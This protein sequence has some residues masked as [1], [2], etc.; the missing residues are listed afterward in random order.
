MLNNREAYL[1]LSAMLRARESRMLTEER[2]RRMLDAPT[3]EDA[4][5]LLTDCGYEDMSGMNA[6]EIEAALAAHRDGI[7]EEISRLAPDSV[8]PD[9]FK[10]KYDYHNAKVILKSEAMNLDPDALLVSSGRI[11][12][13]KLKLLYNEEKYSEMP[14]ALGTA[15]EQAKALLARSANPQQTDFLLDRE[16]FGEITACAEESGNDFLK[17]Y[18]AIMIDAANLKSTVRTLRMGK[19]QDFLKSVLIRGGSVDCDRLANADKESLPGLYVCSLLEKAAE[20]GALALQGESLTPF[21]LACDNACNA[22]ISKA[23][24]VSF[25]SEPLT[26]YLAALENEVT[27]VRM[28]LCG[29]LSGVRSEVIG[30]RLRDTYA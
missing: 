14:G 11:P 2:A 22:Y 8:I 9:V 24:L 16:Y 13:T 17:G 28:I 19:G 23:K 25:G 15:M 21:E 3:F 7:I 26:A 10:M 6:R 12:G 4:A 1:C 20:Y 5:K 27:A 29:R 30:E 18:A